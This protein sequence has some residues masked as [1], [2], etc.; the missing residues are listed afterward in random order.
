M[1]QEKEHGLRPVPRK[2]PDRTG[3]GQESPIARFCA[4]RVGERCERRGCQHA[5]VEHSVE[6]S[7]GLFFMYS[8]VYIAIK[9]E[10]EGAWRV[11][12]T[13]ST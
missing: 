1:K 8:M 7:G 11:L 6:H 9:G 10:E 13:G 5:S 4:S 3:R 12:A 2:R